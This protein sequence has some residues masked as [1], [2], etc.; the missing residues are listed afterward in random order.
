MIFQ[1][2]CSPY[3]DSEE[4][5]RYGEKPGRNYGESKTFQIRTKRSA[6]GANITESEPDIATN[7]SI[8]ID[9]KKNTVEEKELFRALTIILPGEEPIN[10]GKSA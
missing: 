3:S 9:K 5:Q 2:S 1:K 6:E 7:S 8:E 4:D 10:S